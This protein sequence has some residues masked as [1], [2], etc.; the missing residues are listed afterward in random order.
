[1]KKTL[2]IL[3]LLE[4]QKGHYP[5]YNS[6]SSPPPSSSHIY[7]DQ[8]VTSHLAKIDE[9][10]ANYFLKTKAKDNCMI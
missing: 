7:S 10:F 1:M 2:R 4:N 9:K 8:K 6:I 5:I 3:N